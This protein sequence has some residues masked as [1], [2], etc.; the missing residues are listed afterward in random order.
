M[1]YPTY[2]EELI[3]KLKKLPSVGARSAERFAFHLID[4][5]EEDLNALGALLTSLKKELT[6]CE[7]CGALEG[8]QGCQ[9]CENSRRN[10]HLLCIVAHYKDV[11]T[12]ENTREFHGVYHVL[13]GLLSPLDGIG[14]EKLHLESLKERLEN[15]PIQEVVLAIDSTLEG[16]ATAL[17]LR[18]E[19]ENCS[20]AV[21]RLAF[22]IPMGS[23]LD[24][25]DG[26]T[27][28]RAFQGRH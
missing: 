22:G 6:I 8:D 10:P 13:G 25:V 17:F 28:A 5:S 24:F 9:F 26:G 18:K 12:I 15:E 3:L 11:F 1:E 4:W 7:T 27:L 14:P 19:L 16:D 2:L 20:V 23:A 21:S